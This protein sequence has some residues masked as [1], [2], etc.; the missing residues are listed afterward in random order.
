MSNYRPIPIL[1]L[2]LKISG[3]IMQTGLLK[4]LIDHTILSKEQ[5]GFRTKLKTDNATCQLTN[6]LTHSFIMRSSNPYKAW[7]QLDTELVIG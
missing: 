2:F 4:H 7:Y 6:S 3:K 1:T 5:Y